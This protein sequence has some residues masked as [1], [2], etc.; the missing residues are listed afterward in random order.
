VAK[1]SKELLMSNSAPSWAI[2]V[3][4]QDVSAGLL[5]QKGECN[6]E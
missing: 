1:T 3:M 5:R 2:E 4:P 6:G